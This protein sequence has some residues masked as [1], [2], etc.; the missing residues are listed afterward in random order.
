AAA[1][2]GGQT[3]QQALESS[4]R[5]LVKSNYPYI[6]PEKQNAFEVGYKALVANRLFVD[7]NYYYSRYTNFILNAVVTRTP[8]AVLVNDAVNT[9]AASE[10]LSGGSQ[11]FQLYTNAE[12]KASA[13][14]ATLGLT[15]NLD[16]GYTLGGNTTWSA[17]ILGKADATKVAPFNT[18]KW[19]TNMSFGNTNVYRNF[20]F[21]INWHWQD[22]FMWYGPFN[23]MRPGPVGA[24]SLIDLQVN[25][26]L[27]KAKAMIKIGASNAL[28]NKIYT[29]YGSPSIGGVYYVSFTIDELL[30]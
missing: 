11:N 3:Q 4:K 29:A 24:Y 30:K 6:S 5:L 13:Q 15:Y 2:A 8:S 16:G 17:F 18:P 7:V 26:K 1:V 27:P 14:G 22:A 23:G 20:G 28:N 12:D 19:S 25:K 9:A 10:I 21:N